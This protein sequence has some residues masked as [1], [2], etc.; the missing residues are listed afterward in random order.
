MERFAPIEFLLLGLGQRQVLWVLLET[1][2]DLFHK[3]STFVLRKRA[4]VGDCVRHSWESSRPRRYPP[5]VQEN[6]KVVAVDFLVAVHIATV[7]L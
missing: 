1:P 6:E 4:D 3:V 2:P 7:D 5:V